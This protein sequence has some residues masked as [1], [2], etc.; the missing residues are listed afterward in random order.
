MHKLSFIG[1]VSCVR[2]LAMT[3]VAFIGFGFMGRVHAACWQ[4]IRGVRVAAVCV[5]NPASL[6]RA[7]KVYGCVGEALPANLPP[8]VAV[9]TDAEKMLA[10]V[11]PDIVDIVLPTALHAAATE[12][13]LAHGAHVL[14]EKPLARDAREADRILRAAARAKGRF[15]VAQCLRF[16]PEYVCL[17]KL[18][19]SNRYGAVTA[20]SFTRLTPPPCAPDGKSW[21]QDE[22]VSGGLALDL[23]IHDADIVNWLFGLPKSVSC[24]AHRASSGALDHLVADYDYP[25]KIVTSEASWS[26]TESFGFTYGFRVHFARATVVYDLRLPAPFMVYPARG[27]P[28]APAF[29]DRDPYQNEIAFFHRLA[30]G[31][32]RLEANPAPLAE[33]R[34]SLALVHAERASAR[35][36]RRIA[37]QTAKGK[38]T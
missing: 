19:A 7:V 30:T 21:F 38:A 14:C 16:A 8:D 20:A 22:S 33:I 3:K 18:V 37:I 35:T 2:L 36:G 5:R 26:A 32:V 29:R 25:D 23:N 11:R 34:A 28:F 9:Y 13:A 27:K 12:R 10:E 15:M 17:K 1:K 4:R 24:R 31:R 6:A